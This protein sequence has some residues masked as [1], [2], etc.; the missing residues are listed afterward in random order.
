MSLEVEVF[1]FIK[2][3]VCTGKTWWVDEESKVWLS[4]TP[5]MPFKDDLIVKNYKLK[6]GR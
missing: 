5:L 6:A 2:F 1:T 4:H 3:E